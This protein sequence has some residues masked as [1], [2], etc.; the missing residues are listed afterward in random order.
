MTG[1][2]LERRMPTATAARRGLTATSATPASVA[3]TERRGVTDDSPYGHERLGGV[4][5][6]LVPPRVRAVAQC[7]ERPGMWVGTQLA[8]IALQSLQLDIERRCDIN[9][10]VGHESARI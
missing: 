2:R 9:K 5:A 8:R 7:I 10:R 4:K 3:S 6:I 1:P